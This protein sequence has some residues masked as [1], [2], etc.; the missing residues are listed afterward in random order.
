[1]DRGVCQSATSS[2][3]GIGKPRLMRV[4]HVTGEAIMDR[5][6]RSDLTIFDEVSHFD[7]CRLKAMAEPDMQSRIVSLHSVGN[8]LGILQV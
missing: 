7:D 3:L 2:D 4:H 8:R 6:Q 5:D 1:M